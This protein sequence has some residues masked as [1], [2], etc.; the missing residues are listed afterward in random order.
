MVRPVGSML[1]SEALNFSRRKF[2]PALAEPHHGGTRGPA[3]G[4]RQR[5]GPGWRRSVIQRTAIGGEYDHP[6]CEWTG[7]RLRRR[8]VDA[9]HVVS[10]RRT[11]PHRNEIRL[12]RRALRCL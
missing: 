12:R 11:W 1:V 2:L 7:A 9:A 3:A 4:N 10:A 6:T 5:H 8:S